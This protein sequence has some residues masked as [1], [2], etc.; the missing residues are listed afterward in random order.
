[1]E[2]RLNIDD[3]F[4]K[5][6]Q[7]KVGGSVKGTDITRDAL[8]IFNWAVEEVAAGRVV[9]STNASGEDVHRLVMPSLTQVESRSK[10]PA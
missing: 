1:M 3:T 10:T 9:L 7:E 2:V 8:T 4:L 5:N 6:I